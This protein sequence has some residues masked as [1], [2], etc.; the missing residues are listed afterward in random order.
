MAML[1][2]QMVFS[3]YTF[4]WASTEFNLSFT[5][6]FFSV[7]CSRSVVRRFGNS[8]LM[9]DHGYALATHIHAYN[10]VFIWFLSNIKTN[11]VQQI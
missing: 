2:N 4:L 5:A 10:V 9:N 8:L 11:R 6:N 1:N 3:K 7:S